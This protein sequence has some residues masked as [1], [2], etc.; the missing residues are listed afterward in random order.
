MK[1]LLAWGERLGG[2]VRAPRLYFAVVPLT[3]PL[4]FA[5]VDSS[6]PDAATRLQAAPPPLPALTFT[7][8]PA[9]SSPLPGHVMYYPIH[10]GDTLGEVF[11]AGGLSPA[12]S[13][14]IVQD[15]GKVV[16]PRRL[17]LGSVIRFHYDDRGEVAAVSMKIVGWGEVSARRAGDAFEVSSNEAPTH[18]EERAVAARIESSLYDAVRAAGESPELVQSLVDVFQ[19]DV[20]FF[21]LQRGDS[22]SMIVRQRFS[23]DDAVGYGPILA[24]QF[25]HK[26][27]VYEAFRY[28][29]PDGSGGYY[30]RGGTPVKKQFLKA[31]LKFT[32][33]TSGFSQH[34]FH[35][36]LKIF[37]PHHGVDYGAPVGT[38]VMSTADGVVSFTG[39]DRGEGN[40]IRIRHNSRLETW[41]LHLSRFRSGLKPGQRV[42]QGDVIGYVGAT[43]LATGPHLDYRVKDAGN[44]LNP[45][46]LR[47]ITP[48]PLRGASLRY[49]RTAVAQACT[50][51]EEKAQQ[52]ASGTMPHSETPAP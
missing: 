32:R 50:R 10:S 25:T 30:T 40:Y 12:Q 46:S 42:Q 52:I 19:W 20:D 26:G 22:F 11:A 45:L 16:D 5:T 9:P 31:P 33:I 37:R 24:A 7:A 21:A 6:R 28:E 44:W 39:Y 2:M 47:S 48:D 1:K 4:I 35:P 43:G 17:R 13:Y 18:T 15:F 51:L 3:I 49:F 14:A 41:Y 36:I 27:E 23:G 29:Q 34:R 38:P 8:A